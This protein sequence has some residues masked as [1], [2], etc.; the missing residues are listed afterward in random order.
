MD[1]LFCKIINRDIPADIVYEDEDVLAFN[2]INPQAP[3]HVL[4]VPKQHVATLNDLEEDNLPLV[5]RLSFAAAKLAKEY[6][7]AEDGYRVV[8]NCNEKGGQTVYHIHMHLMGGRRFTWP[9]G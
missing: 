5:G 8:L 6:G 3:T 2:D 9:A 4:L 7:F 1:C